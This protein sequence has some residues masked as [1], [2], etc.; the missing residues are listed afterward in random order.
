MSLTSKA[1]GLTIIN[2]DGNAMSIIQADEKEYLELHVNGEYW[3][4]AKTD[5]PELARLFANMA[6][7]E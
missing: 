5:L 1:I 2:E 4:F 3:G 6:E 7:D